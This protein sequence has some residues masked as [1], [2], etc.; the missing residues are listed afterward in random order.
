MSGCRNT[1]LKDPAGN[2]IRPP[3]LEEIV[4]DHVVGLYGEILEEY[5]EEFEDDE[6]DPDIILFHYLA[7]I[8]TGI[9]PRIYFE[10]VPTWMLKALPPYLAKL[11]RKGL[12]G[13]HEMMMLKVAARMGGYKG[14]DDG[15][16]GTPMESLDDSDF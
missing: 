14:Y 1:L 8:Y 15:V 16:M 12:I 3:G 10:E 5:D 13:H 11:W 4:K 2:P 9:T 7:N 6:D